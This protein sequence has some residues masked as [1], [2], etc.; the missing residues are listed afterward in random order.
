MVTRRRMLQSWL[1][2]WDHGVILNRTLQLWPTFREAEEWGKNKPQTLA[3][4]S[5]YPPIPKTEACPEC[6][7]R[8][9]A[10]GLGVLCS[11]NRL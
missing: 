4:G 6:N 3:V 1:G 9:G 11:S 8:G 7:P 5:I 2:G 10:L